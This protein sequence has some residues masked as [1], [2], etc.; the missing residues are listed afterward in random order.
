MPILRPRVRN[1]QI[2]MA[3]FKRLQEFPI[4]SSIELSK[5]KILSYM[6]IGYFFR[7]AQ[8]G[9]QKGDPEQVGPAQG[10][11]DQHLCHQGQ[12]LQEK[13]ELHRRLHGR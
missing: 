12:A 5:A 6:Y 9:L 13:Y 10:R 4:V 7:P 2:C 1:V 3:I 11:Q 8:C